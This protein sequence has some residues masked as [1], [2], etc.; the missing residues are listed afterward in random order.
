MV[1]KKML[2]IILTPLG[3]VWTDY[4]QPDIIT[5][6]KFMG[7][8]SEIAEKY[9]NVVE[10]GSLPDEIDQLPHD[11]PFITDQRFLH[12]LLVKSEKFAQADIEVESYKRTY[13]IRSILYIKLTLEE[14]NTLDEVNRLIANIIVQRT[15]ESRDIYIAQAIHAIDDLTKTINLFGN[16]L[17]EWYGVHFPEIVDV[18]S[19][20]QQMFKFIYQLGVR[21][22]FVAEKLSDIS[23]KK[24]E[25]IGEIVQKSLGAEITMEDLVPM[26]ELASLGLELEKTRT[27]LES[28]IE[29][30]STNVMPNTVRL[31]GPLIAS[32]LL[33]YAGSLQNLAK[34]PAS[35]IQLLGAERALFR[36]L[37]GGDKPPKHGIIFQSGQIHQAPFHQRGKI[38]RAL[39]G[40]ISIAARIDYFTGGEEQAS[41][42]EEELKRR[43][44][45]ITKRFPNPPTKK[46]QFP[47]RETF[48]E[49]SR[50]D[51]EGRFPRREEFSKK[52][53]F[54]EKSRTDREG[55]FP[56]REG[57]S[58]KGT[59][60]E[61]SRTDREVRFPRREGLSK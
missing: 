31:V 51:R 50:T 30:A 38:A 5:W 21:Q 11:Q 25:R 39:A 8:T 56:R 41:K 61:K 58:K 48:A 43:V 57:L 35:T 16:R 37:R 20:I 40:K 45:D 46:K 52:G 12:D 34:M 19:D 27:K 44:D 9:Y 24:R 55:R 29:I 42:L 32:R 7:S 1:L 53:T 33:A 26:Q 4:N 15:S 2:F 49:K 36:H 23:D 60:A 17:T 59:F 22:N 3:F 13:S 6:I 28:Y 54:A 10:E 47:R 18:T 14:K